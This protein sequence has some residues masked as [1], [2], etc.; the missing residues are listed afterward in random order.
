MNKKELIKKLEELKHILIYMLLFRSKSKPNERKINLY[1]KA[2][3]CVSYA[4]KLLNYY[5]YKYISNTETLFK[6]VDLKDVENYEILVNPTFKLI[7]E[8]MHE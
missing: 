1:K 2:F 5:N 8:Y 4:Q 3:F 7:E 6:Y